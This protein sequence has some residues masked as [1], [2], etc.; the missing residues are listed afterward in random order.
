MRFSRSRTTSAGRFK[1]NL[2]GEETPHHGRGS[3]GA[4][5]D[6]TNDLRPSERGPDPVKEMKSAETHIFAL[7]GVDTCSIT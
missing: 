4:D 5:Q 7:P 3:N 2:V 1:E 6:D